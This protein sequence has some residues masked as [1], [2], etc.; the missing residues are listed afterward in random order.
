M[1]KHFSSILFLIFSFSAVNAQKYYSD[2]GKVVDWHERIDFFWGRIFDIDIKDY[3]TKPIQY[4]TTILI[5][6]EEDGT[7]KL[8]VYMPNGNKVVNYVVLCLYNKE[9]NK[10]VFYHENTD[11]GIFGVLIDRAYLHYNYKN[12]T[13][14]VFSF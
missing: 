8:I 12:N 10:Y 1:K 3:T 13:Y 6:I 9:K 2:S 11:E 5:D 7:G 4:N 14:H